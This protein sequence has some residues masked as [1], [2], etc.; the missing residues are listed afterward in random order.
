MHPG[1]Y[2]NPESH[3]GLERSQ[4]KTQTGACAQPGSAAAAAAERGRESDHSHRK[5]LASSGRP[6]KE[7]DSHGIDFREGGIG[8]EGTQGSRW[9]GT[10]ERHRARPATED[11]G[12]DDGGG[13]RR[14][15]MAMMV[16]GKEGWDQPLP[17][18][19]RLPEAVAA[20]ELAAAA[21]AETHA[22][23][24]IEKGGCFGSWVSGATTGGTLRR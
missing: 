19:D 14:R 16:A 6:L 15:W 23:L 18:Q 9:E 10:E 11:D 17:R 8:Y 5:T 4:A 21:A 13:D 12:D 24:G 1:N 7:S 2:L 3:R 20:A 22:R